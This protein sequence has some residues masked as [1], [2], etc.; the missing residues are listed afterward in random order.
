MRLEGKVALIAGAG[1]R[2]GRGIP[3]VFAQEGARL[4]LVSRNEEHLAETVRMARAAGGEVEW[5][6][7]DLL[8]PL[9]SARAVALARERFGG[10]DIVA[11]V[12]GGF[13]D[14]RLDQDPV[15][16]DF[17]NRA[18]ANL[19]QTMNNVCQAAHS[20]LRER[21]GGSIINVSAAPITR[22]NNPAYG[23]GKDG[24]LGFTRGLARRLA[25]DNIRVNTIS[26]GRIRLVVPE[27]PLQPADLQAGGRV[28]SS[29]PLE[30]MGSGLDVAYA[31]L[32][33]AADESVWVTG[34]ELIVDGGDAVLAAYPERA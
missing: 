1:D 31:A 4:V 15:E 24:M 21:G 29:R 26:P 8:D 7:G 3:V 34:A 20:A 10:V 33:F 9:T 23:A 2:M 6:A 16:I 18:T 17:F 11:N 5:L 32:Y 27:P 14:A 28:S 22:L 25:A 19:L 13:A 12:A 30:R